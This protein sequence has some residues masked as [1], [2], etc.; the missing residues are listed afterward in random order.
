MGMSLAVAPPEAAGT[1]LSQFLLMLPPALLRS[2]AGT[3]TGF[4]ILFA[5]AMASPGGCG[6][7]GGDIKL[8][9]AM[10]FYLSWPEL[11]LTLLGGCL[12]GIIGAA[13]A[14][15]TG[16][17]PFGPYLAAAGACRH[18]RPDYEP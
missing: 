5:A 15:K 14:R 2:L 17:I 3:A 11:L 8:L 13:A 12:L 7:G 16:A 4:L 6:V 9:L 18:S 10:A 1:P